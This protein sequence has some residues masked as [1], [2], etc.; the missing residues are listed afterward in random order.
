[1][2]VLAIRDLFNQYGEDTVKQ[3]DEKEFFLK[4]S[5]FR[6]NMK[7]NLKKWITKYIFLGY[8][9]KINRSMIYGYG[10]FY[11]EINEKYFIYKIIKVLLK[12]HF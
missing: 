12:M 8:P 11:E 3:M 9:Q 7:M 5:Q 6:K 1:M 2:I 4:R 10:G